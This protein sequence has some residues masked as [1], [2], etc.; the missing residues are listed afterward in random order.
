MKYLT[1]R[2]E[3]ASLILPNKNE[4]PKKNK[5]G[6]T[7]RQYTQGVGITAYDECDLENP[8]GADQL[9]NVL[10][11][12][13]GLAPIPTKR[14]TI[15]TRNEELYNIAKNSY[16]KYDKGCNNDIDRKSEMFQASKYAED[17]HL[18][19]S[20]KIGDEV[21]SGFYN[22]AYFLRRF[23]K[24]K[25]LLKKILNFFNKV[26]SS[27]NVMKD[28]KFD[29]FVIEFHK[30]LSDD[31]VKAFDAENRKAYSDKGSPLG[32]P[33][34]AVIFEAKKPLGNN[35]VYF[36]STPILA[37]HSV[38]YKKGKLSGTIIIPIE[39]E[40]IIEQIRNCGCNPTI[41]DGGLV[42]I[43]ELKNRINE[44]ILET[45]YTKIH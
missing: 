16:I 40:D 8:I 41:L 36:Q 14:K 19:I 17:S 25:D 12:M 39:N 22:W 11:V 30:H 35:T 23:Y 31:D 38:E 5:K 27:E 34:Y 24:N 28:Y 1:I 7:F 13:C 20:T 4:T 37:S 2:F 29:E 3:N 26:L 44:T 15:F 6:L 9:S 18:Q 33:F 10:H 45:D 43:V 21:Y 32:G 42:T